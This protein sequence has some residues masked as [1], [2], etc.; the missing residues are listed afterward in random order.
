MSH[1]PVS[2]LW[3][4]V[5]VLLQLA[6]LQQQTAVKWVDGKASGATSGHRHARLGTW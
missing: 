2:G 6:I 3:Q 5:S 1:S 4:L